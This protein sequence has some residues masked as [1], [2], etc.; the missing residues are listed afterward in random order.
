MKVMKPLLVLLGFMSFSATAQIFIGNY[1][2]YYSD[3][4]LSRQL[5]DSINAYR[6]S[7]GQKSIIWEENYY[8]TAKKHNDYLAQNGFWGH[9]NNGWGTELIV[10]VTLTDYGNIRTHYRFVYTTMAAFTGPPSVS[11]CPAVI[12]NANLIQDKMGRCNI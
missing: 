12:I 10:G 4:Q 2:S 6:N 9:R 11:Y 3:K 1:I 5:F 7:V 8:V